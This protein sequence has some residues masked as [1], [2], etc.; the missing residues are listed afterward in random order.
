MSVT[1]EQEAIDEIFTDD[2]TKTIDDVIQ[3]LVD[4]IITLSEKEII[5][6]MKMVFERMKIVIEP[7]SSIVLAAA[8]KN[9]QEFKG[10]QVGLIFSGGNIDCDNLPW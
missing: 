1:T 3:K 5:L 6:S 10:K 9:K 8:L 7:S 2:D 4:G